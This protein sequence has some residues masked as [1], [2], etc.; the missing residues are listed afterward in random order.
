M[1]FLYLQYIT[2]MHITVYNFTE[3]YL[4]PVYCYSFVCLFDC[5]FVIS[6]LLNPAFFLSKIEKLNGGRWLLQY[7]KK[8]RMHSTKYTIDHE[9]SLQI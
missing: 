2:Y 3:N 9:S 6:L 7:C 8:P 4:T 5:L 1:D